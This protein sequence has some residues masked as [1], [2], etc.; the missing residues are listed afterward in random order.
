MLTRE[1]IEAI[2]EGDE[3]EFT[4]TRGDITTTSRAVVGS[5]DT[6]SKRTELL[7]Q[8]GYVFFTFVDGDPYNVSKRVK[9]VKKAP[10]KL[11]VGDSDMTVD[12]LKSL[13]VRTLF[14]S[15][16]YSEWTALKIGE[17]EVV[18]VGASLTPNKYPLAFIADNAAVGIEYIPEVSA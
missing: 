18:V 13:P 14:K 4:Y 1:D 6:R 12:E 3:V 8:A 16:V 10:R 17:N 5:L 9:I 15:L 11:E 2:G 7:T